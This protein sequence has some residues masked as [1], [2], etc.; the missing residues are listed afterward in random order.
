MKFA[1]Q[2]EPKLCTMPGAFRD[3]E[4]LYIYINDEPKDSPN[5]VQV[6]LILRLRPQGMVQPGTLPKASVVPICAP[7]IWEGQWAELLSP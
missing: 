4:K 7:C 6:V 2:K 1:N 5:C 3:E